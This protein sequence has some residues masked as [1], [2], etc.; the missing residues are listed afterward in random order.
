MSEE[1][2]KRRNKKERGKSMKEREE[3]GKNEKKKESLLNS[4]VSVTLG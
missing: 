2:E 4:G 1:G 3:K